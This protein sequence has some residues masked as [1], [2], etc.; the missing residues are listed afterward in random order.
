MSIT[1]SFVLK[2]YGRIGDEIT[3]LNHGM[4]EED[5]RHR[6]MWGN[7]VL[8]EERPLYSGQPLDGVKLC[9]LYS[10]CSSGVQIVPACHMHLRLTLLTVGSVASIVT[11][12]RNLHM[13]V[14]FTAGS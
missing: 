7:L 4:T 1:F 12:Y 13:N 11:L 9:A 6:A 8:G 10:E 3:V 5:T 14:T 2:K